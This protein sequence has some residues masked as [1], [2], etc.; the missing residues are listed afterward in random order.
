MV[1]VEEDFKGV[2]PAPEGRP[3]SV[4]ESSEYQRPDLQHLPLIP[5][6][7]TDFSESNRALNAEKMIQDLYKILMKV[8][9]ENK[10]LRLSLSEQQSIIE[11][12]VGYN[13]LKSLK[14]FFCRAPKLNFF[15]FSI[16]PSTL[17]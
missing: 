1:L 6:T 9:A 8:T 17:L 4:H 12:E 13:S 7:V 15:S 11:C 10:N 3:P 5:T 2:P 14:S 16:T